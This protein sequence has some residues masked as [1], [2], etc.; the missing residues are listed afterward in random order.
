MKN[1][2]LTTI[3]FL[4]AF[5]AA[6]FIGCNALQKFA[7]GR[8]VVDDGVYPAS[9]VVMDEDDAKKLTD[10]VPIHLYFSGGDNNK[11]F[12]E[13]RHIPISEAKKSV[14]HLASII[15]KELIK[16]P[17]RNGK[18][19]P[20]IPENTKLN[21]A[22]VI[23]KGVATVDLSKEFVDKHP[24][25]KI[26]EQLTIYSIVN[27]LT[28]LKEIQKVRFNVEGKENKE[29]KGYYRFENTFSRDNLLISR[30]ATSED[31]KQKEN[32]SEQSY[33]EILD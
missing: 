8:Q 15:I 28:E 14:N 26:E 4:I 9:S 23:S 7:T 17:E 13:V 3:V 21:S 11:L 25:G 6:N 18:L 33:T 32:I 16:G 31:A 27:S 30:D 1:L 12:L 20:T 22:V 2:K 19:R 29:F 10:K 24:G 5:M